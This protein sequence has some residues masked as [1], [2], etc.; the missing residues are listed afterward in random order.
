MCWKFQWHKWKPQKG[1][2]VLK[3][4]W[5]HWHINKTVLEC[6]SLRPSLP[7]QLAEVC[8]WH[9][10]LGLARGVP[11][12][13][14]GDI[15]QIYALKSFCQLVT[16]L[17][18]VPPIP[19]WLIICKT[20]LHSPEGNKNISTSTAPQWTT[21]LF[22]LHIC[23]SST[24]MNKALVMTASLQRPWS[25]KTKQHNICLGAHTILK[26]ENN[27]PKRQNGSDF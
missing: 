27:K 26:G 20:K 11:N 21:A 25:S 16:Y 12:N 3:S 17:H 24:G 9:L 10:C 8:Y 14:A 22:A 6:S 4:V 2:C 7:E 13:K 19:N 18:M 1:K 15:S 5:H 23:A